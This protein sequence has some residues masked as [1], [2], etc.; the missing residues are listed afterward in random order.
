M[1]R[2]GHPGNRGSIL[3]SGEVTLFAVFRA[4][5][6]NTQFLIQWVPKNLPLEVKRPEYEADH[7]P[8][9]IAKF[10]NAWSGSFTTAN[11]FHDMVLD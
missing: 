1:A 5:L 3:G 6:G 2:A 9:S 4:A 7:S 8:P 11:D 10:K